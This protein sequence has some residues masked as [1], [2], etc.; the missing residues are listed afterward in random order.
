FDDNCGGNRTWRDQRRRTT[1][2]R[3]EERIPEPDYCCV[4]ELRR[5]SDPGTHTTRS[6]QNPAGHWTRLFETPRRISTCV[7]RLC[8]IV[9]LER[10]KQSKNRPMEL[11]RYC[12]SDSSLQ[13]R[14]F[15]TVCRALKK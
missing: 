10:E 14:S 1:T 12:L 5:D 7:G 6:H 9:G 3:L 11:P 2:A 13:C 15:R 4:L 8:A